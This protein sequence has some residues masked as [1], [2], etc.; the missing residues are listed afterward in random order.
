M[1]QQR[2]QR[3]KEQYGFVGQSGRLFRT[4]VEFTDELDDHVVRRGHNRCTVEHFLFFAVRLAI[5][6]TVRLQQ[7]IDTREDQHEMID[8]EP[9]GMAKD[10]HRTCVHARDFILGVLAEQQQPFEANGEH[11]LREH[12]VQIGCFVFRQAREDLLRVRMIVLHGVE[13]IGEHETV[14]PYV[15]VDLQIAELVV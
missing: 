14:H 6:R 11:L 3:T 2:W 10:A 4:L 1:G 8:V 7:D 13:Q 15:Q 12:I 9:F 5:A